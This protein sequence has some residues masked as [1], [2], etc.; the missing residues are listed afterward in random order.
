MTKRIKLL[1]HH[2]PSPS[3][4][5]VLACAG[6]WA[7]SFSLRAGEKLSEARASPLDEPVT[8]PAENK[9][10]WKFTL[11]S[12]LRWEYAEQDGLDRS[13]AVTLR[14]RAGLLLGPFEGFSFFAEYEGTLA[15]ER[16]SY[17]AAS[18]HGFGQNKTIIADPESHELNQL[19]LHYNGWNS[20]LK[21]GRQRI[22]LD[23]ARFVGNVGWR[24]NE[25]TFDA[26]TLT[27]S[28]V[29]DLTL[30]YGYIN[31]VNR[32]FGSGHIRNDAQKDFKGD[33]HLFNVSYAFDPALTLTSY[34]Y[35]LDLHNSAG[36]TASN[37]TFGLLAQGK[38][39]AGKLTIP[40]LLEAAFQTEGADSPLDYEAWYFRADAGIATERFTIGA[41]FEHLGSGDEAA[42]QTPLATL[43][44]FN[45]WADVFLATPPGGLNDAYVY[46]DAKLSE[47]VLLKT[48]VHWFGSDSGD[49]E[50]GQ[51]FDAALTYQINKYFS[52]GAKFARYFADEYAA[53]L[54][55]FILDVTFRY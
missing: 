31:R 52:V 48:Q 5:L 2:F 19:W 30:F 47:N 17:Q 46:V 26:V 29:E 49:F 8:D 51:E 28:S 1:P 3:L 32:I 22:I 9:P 42:F 23:D 45:G 50:Y 12:R 39:Q 13:N 36:D 33:S 7:L 16:D 27:N 18:V 34:A 4:A 10:P 38:V 11:D 15:A 37:H 55:R 43:H 41:G 54:D 40:Y 24:Q 6:C 44:A 25:Q 20:D 14:N 53:D 35:F 21:V